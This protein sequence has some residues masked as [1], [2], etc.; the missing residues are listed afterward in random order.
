MNMALDMVLLDQ[1][2]RRMSPPTLRLYRWDR[3]AISVGRYQNAGRTVLLETCRA[4]GVPVVRRPTGGRGVL[5]GGDLTIALAAPIPWLEPGHTSVAASHALILGALSEALRE[6]GCASRR[7]DAGGQLSEP[8]SGDC[9]SVATQ[10]DLV[11]ADGCKAAGGAQARSLGVL[12]EQ[13]SLPHHPHP[14]DPCRVFGAGASLYDGRLGCV[15]NASLEAAA[16][17]CIASALGA[18][19]TVGAW[20]PEELLAASGMRSAVGVDTQAHL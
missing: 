8:G 15:P 11:Y 4:L 14:V 20:R 17:R 13:I 3:P 16:S 9:F 18:R 5:H 19:L 10:A 2:G 1:V 12:L 7:G 6:V